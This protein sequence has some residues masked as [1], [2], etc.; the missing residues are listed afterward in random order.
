MPEIIFSLAEER[1]DWLELRKE[2][3]KKNKKEKQQE[4]SYIILSFFGQFNH[5]QT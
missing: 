3:R 2:T 4:Y 1:R 5:P